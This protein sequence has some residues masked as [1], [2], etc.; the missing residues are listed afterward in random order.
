MSKKAPYKIVPVDGKF[1][2]F[3]NETERTIIK[4]DN[5]K[6]AAAVIRKIKSGAFFNGF[7]PQFFGVIELKKEQNNT[8]VK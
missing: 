3:E 2:V 7:T 4:C 6:Q 8:E 1:D 5:W